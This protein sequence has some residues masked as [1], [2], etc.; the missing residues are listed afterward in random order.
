MSVFNNAIDFI[1]ELGIFDVVLP[2]LLVF[3]IIF[4]ILE[5]TKVLGTEEIDGKKYTKK[6]LDSI[7]AFVVAFFVVGSAQLVQ[8]INSFMANIVLLLLLVV[9]F[10][11]LVGVFFKEGEGVF[12]E[13]GPW[14]TLWMIILFVGIILV[15]LGSIKNSDGVSWLEVF[16]NFLSDYWSTEGVAALILLIVVIL[17]MW[18]VTKDNKPK[19]A[20][21][22][23][24]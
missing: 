12:L 7:V 22:E 19:E 5:K 20:K 24:K 11:V 9:F 23:E 17:F 6:N 2:F 16:W 15:F 18:F 10:L 8:A 1:V 14:K 3:A 21:K 13:D 4:A